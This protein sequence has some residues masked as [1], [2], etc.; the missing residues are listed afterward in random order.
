VDLEVKHKDTGTRDSPAPIAAAAPPSDLLPLPAPPSQSRVAGKLGPSDPK[1]L[2][3]A[4]SKS[5]HIKAAPA[6]PGKNRRPP[7][8]PPAPAVNR[9]RGSVRTPLG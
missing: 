4:G 7:L 2:I 1:H 8:S 6:A 9:G 3:Y 5:K